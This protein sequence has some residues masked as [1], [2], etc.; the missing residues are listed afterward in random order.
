MP[1]CHFAKSVVTK[2]DIAFMPFS[3]EAFEFYQEINALLDCSIGIK[4]AYLSM[5]SEVKP[6]L[7]YEGTTDPSHD[8]NR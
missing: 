7:R 5:V 6:I 3:A 2:Y 1:N 4:T 8:K